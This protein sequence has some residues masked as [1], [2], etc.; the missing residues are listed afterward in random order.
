MFYT[1]QPKPYPLFPMLQSLRTQAYADL[2]NI[3][4]K[5]KLSLFIEEGMLFSP[6][7]LFVTVLMT[8][9]V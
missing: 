8:C 6:M 5:P 4:D 2:L 3:P 1:P 9:L 7:L